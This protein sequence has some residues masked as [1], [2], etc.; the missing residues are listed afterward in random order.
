MRQV[1]IAK[2]Q[3]DKLWDYALCR[4]KN[5]DSSWW[6]VCAEQFGINPIAIKKCALSKEGLDLLRE[7]TGLNKELEMS[8]GPVFLVNNNEV[9]AAK[10]FSRVEELEKLLGL[11]PHVKKDKD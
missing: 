2:Y 8:I 4:F 3:P 9:Y 11:V 5:Q 10:N 7:N 6:E 1:C